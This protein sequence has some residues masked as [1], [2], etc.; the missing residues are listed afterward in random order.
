MTLGAILLYKPAILPGHDLAWKTIAI[1]PFIA[2]VAVR[3]VPGVSIAVDAWR[4]VS[5][6]RRR[7]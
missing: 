5:D 2:A 6:R 3:L 4:A 1:L 7:G